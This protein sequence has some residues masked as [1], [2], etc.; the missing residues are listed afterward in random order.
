ML[1]IET[2]MTGWLAP[3]LLIGGL[4]LVGASVLLTMPRM[5]A[6]EKQ[7]ASALLQ[8]QT[9]EQAAPA[10]TVSSP[11]SVDQPV[12]AAQV[13][14]AKQLVSRALDNHRVL[15]DKIAKL[16]AERDVAN[17]NAAKLKAMLAANE[18]K[19]ADVE[20]ALTVQRDLLMHAGQR[21]LAQDIELEQYRS[22]AHPN[23]TME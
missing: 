13:A 2:D 11:S 5:R 16:E 23:T 14:E 1:G 22:K 20:H 4:M 21:L 15:T 19:L 7:L 17:A 6:A 12:I 3:G 8:L 18:K 9:K 10:A